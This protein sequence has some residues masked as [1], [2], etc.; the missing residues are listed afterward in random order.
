M[1]GRSVFGWLGL[2]EG[3]LL[4]L[5][6]VATYARPESAIAGFVMLYGIMAIVVGIIDILLYVRMERYTGFGPV[7]SL[8]SGILSVMTGLMLL[9]Y[10][11][12]GKIILTILF[13]LWFISHCISRLSSL[14]R[15]RLFSGNFAYCF[16]LILNVI[17]LILGM[18]ML[19]HPWLSLLSIRY[20]ISFYLILLGIDCILLSVSQFRRKY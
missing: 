18:M 15:I 13:P 8:I 19:I 1:K 17:G 14:N 12:A 20:I 10:P 4:I 5:L 3:I 2:A 11:T 6:G 16:T 9:V 7:V